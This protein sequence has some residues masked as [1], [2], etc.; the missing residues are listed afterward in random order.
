[1]PKPRP[2]GPKP[3][4]P[5]ASKAAPLIREIKNRIV[6]FVIFPPPVQNRSRPGGPHSQAGLREAIR[7]PLRPHRREPFRFHSPPS[8]PDQCS[9]P[10]LSAPRDKVPRA[11]RSAALPG[12]AEEHMEPP[13]NLHPGRSTRPPKPHSLRSSPSATRPLQE[14]DAGVPAPSTALAASPAQSAGPPRPPDR[15]P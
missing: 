11:S 7:P 12:P 1:M 6:F 13:H 2:R 4:G 15:F 14:P 5:C 9:R 10:E 8:S 3:G